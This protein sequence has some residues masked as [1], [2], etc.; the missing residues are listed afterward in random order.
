MTRSKRYPRAQVALI[1]G[2][3]S[4][5]GLEIT[6]QLGA[7]SPSRVCGAQAHPATADAACAPRCAA[8]HGAHCV[9]V[10]RR[11]AVVADTV[12]LLRQEG[13]AVDGTAADVRSP[14]RC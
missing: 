14:V 7:P 2:G 12:A 8:L 3:G 6:R 4:G 13:L 5:I 1:T 9:I 11:A 10:G